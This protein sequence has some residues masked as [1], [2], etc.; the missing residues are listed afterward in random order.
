MD[1]SSADEQDNPPVSH[2]T[3]VREDGYTPKPQKQLQDT[4]EYIYEDTYEY[5]YEEKYQIYDPP[6]QNIYK[7]PT[8]KSGKLLQIAASDL[9][10]RIIDGFGRLEEPTHL[11]AVDDDDPIST[12]FRDALRNAMIDNDLAISYEDGTSPFMLL[13]GEVGRDPED[14]NRAVLSLILTKRDEILFNATD[15]YTVDTA[16]DI[17]SNDYDDSYNRDRKR[18][19]SNRHIYSVND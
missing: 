6:P 9:L 15:T 5:S 4:S 17:V 8:T 18:S 12:E 7:K 13:Y 14:N 1:S 10:S 19:R 2:L 16:G 11:I 3:Y